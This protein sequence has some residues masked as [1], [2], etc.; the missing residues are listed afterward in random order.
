[1]PECLVSFFKQRRALDYSTI[2]LNR[3]LPDFAISEM[4]PLSSINFSI[5][6]LETI[7][8]VVNRYSSQ[9]F[10]MIKF[11][12]IIVPFFYQIHY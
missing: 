8:S 6:Y 5:K 4:F 7:I 2:F 9:S 10:I 12:L 1:M 3:R 11:V